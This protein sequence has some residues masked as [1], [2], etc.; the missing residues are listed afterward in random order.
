MTIIRQANGG[1]PLIRV[2]SNLKRASVGLLLLAFFLFLFTLTPTYANASLIDAR[3]AS[4]SINVEVDQVTHTIK[5][6]DGGLVIIN[7]T[8]K[9]FPKPPE[10]EVLLQN[11]SLGFPYKINDKETVDTLD[12]SFAY[13]ASKPDEPFKVERNVGLEG[14]I[15]FYGAN[16]IFPEPGLNVSSGGR[17][18]TVVSVF[19]NLISPVPETPTLFN[20]TF[21]MYPSLTQNASTCDVTVVLPPNA[22]YTDSVFQKEDLNFTLTTVGTSQILRHTKT[23]LDN[24]QREPA[25]ITSN[26]TGLVFPL[27]NINEVRREIKLDQWGDLQLSDFYDITNKGPLQDSLT[28]RLPRGASAV[29]ARDEFDDLTVGFTK[30]NVTAITNA[31]IY[32]RQGKAL[33]ED[34]DGK[35]TVTYRL[36]WKEY[37]DRRNGDDYDLSFT[38]FENFDWTIR[39]LT[40][41]V[42]LPEGAEFQSSSPANPSKIEK[43]AFQETITFSFFNVTPFHDLDFNFTYKYLTFWASFR[44]TLWVGILVTVV[45]AIVLFWRAPKLPSV[46]IVPV[47]HKDLRSFVDAYEGKTGILSELESMEQKLRKGRIPRRRYKVRK[48]MLEGRLS[49][50]SRELTGLREKMRAAGARYANI[51]RQIEVAETM[52][53]GVETDIRR[54]ESRYKRG[55]I[56]KGAY[57]RLLEE[58]RRRRE[59]AKTTIDE[60]LLRLKEEIR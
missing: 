22:N 12:Y 2:V 47:P 11:L 15:G 9:L 40:V 26:M 33:G 24:F 52:L 21:P 58:Y 43:S 4:S 49:T 37:V 7:D 59:R 34:E 30:E 31:T 27:V 6:Q 14:R 20:T 50:L 39:E 51:M 32:F 38:F 35:F 45:G 16:V 44:P 57:G 25:W 53:E 41:T 48:R 36:P 13:D 19:S 5:I 17:D 29:S 54:V 18:L 55:D 3:L 28:V 56:S 42:I 8:L 60:A 1:N 10:T 46:P 23:S